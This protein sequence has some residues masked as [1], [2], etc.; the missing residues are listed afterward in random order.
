M[1][2][3]LS[4][5]DRRIG[6][7]RAERDGIQRNISTIGVQ[8]QLEVE[9]SRRYNELTR[10]LVQLDNRRQKLIATFGRANSLP[11]TPVS[12]P[13]PVFTPTT[14]TTGSVE[15]IRRIADRER[16]QVV[17][18]T[19][20]NVALRTRIDVLD[21]QLTDMTRR[22]T[23]NTGMGG[24]EAAALTQQ[25][26]QMR[27]LRDAAARELEAARETERRMRM[28]VND[29][30]N[31]A[32]MIER[33]LRQELTVANNQLSDALQ[34]T[35]TAQATYQS[36][37]GA[38][39][40]RIETFNGSGADFAAQRQRLADDARQIETNHATQLAAARNNQAEAERRAAEAMRVAGEERRRLAADAD[41]QRRAFEQA[42]AARRA[43]NAAALAENINRTPAN[44]A[45]LGAAAQDSRLAERNAAEA[46]RQTAAD[47]QSL[48]DATRV[49][50]RAAAEASAAA[51]LT[52]AAALDQ[53]ET[54]RLA[55]D[56]QQ[57]SGFVGGLFG[58][59]AGA[60]GFGGGNRQQ[61]PP[62]PTLGSAT[63]SEGADNELRRA[64]EALIGPA[65]SG[66]Q[67]EVRLVD[68]IGRYSTAVY[69]WFDENRNG[70]FASGSSNVQAETLARV[71]FYGTRNSTLQEA[72]QPRYTQD[73]DGLS[74]D[75]TTHTIKFYATGQ[76]MTAVV[77]AL[78]NP[79]LAYLYEAPYSERRN[80]KKVLTK[81]VVPFLW[82]VIDAIDRERVAA[83]T[84]EPQLEAAW[85]FMH[86]VVQWLFVKLITKSELSGTDR[87]MF[88]QQNSANL[89]AT[90]SENRIFGSL[91]SGIATFTSSNETQGSIGNTI[92]GRAPIRAADGV[93]V[94]P[95]IGALQTERVYTAT[96]RADQLY[97]IGAMQMSDERF[98]AVFAQNT[99][100][101]INAARKQNA[102][103][104]SKMFRGV[105]FALDNVSK[106]YSFAALFGQSAVM[107]APSG[108]D[109]DS[110]L[111]VSLFQRLFPSAALVEQHP[112]ASDSRHSIFHK[113]FT[114]LVSPN[115]VTFIGVEALPAATEP[116]SAFA[117]VI[118]PRADIVDKNLELDL[119]IV[120][121]IGVP[122]VSDSRLALAY[123]A[124]EFTLLARN[125]ES[126][127]RG[128]KLYA[129]VAAYSLLVPYRLNA[130]DPTPNKR[131]IERFGLRPQF[132]LPTSAND[133]LKGQ[134][135]VK[136]AAKPGRTTQSRV[137]P[138]DID[139][140]ERMHVAAELRLPGETME[141]T[142]IR[143]ARD[144]RVVVPPGY[145]LRERTGLRD[146][147]FDDAAQARLLQLNRMS[148]ETLEDT[149]R[150]L[151][152]ENRWMPELDQA[153]RMELINGERMPDETV[154]AA[155]L[156][157][158]REGR[159]G[160]G[161]A[162][163]D[164]EMR[165]LVANYRYPNESVEETRRRLVREGRLPIES[166]DET[167]RRLLAEGRLYPGEMGR[168]PDYTPA[169]VSFSRGREKKPN[170]TDEQ[171]RLRLIGEGKLDGETPEMTQLRLI[172]EGPKFGESY[173]AWRSR[174]MALG[175]IPGE[176]VAE[177][178][179]RPLGAPR[180]IGA[181]TENRG[182]KLAEMQRALGESDEEYRY[183]LINGGSGLDTMRL[184]G[185]TEMAFQ[186]RILSR[187]RPGLY[188][189]ED[190]RRRRLI[191]ELRAT[192]E[193]P[194]QTE[195][196][197]IREGK[198]TR[199][200][201]W[202]VR[203]RL[204]REGVILGE[205]PE[206]TRRRI[207]RESFYSPESLYDG[208]RALVTR[209]VLPDE[210]P[211]ETRQRL[212]SQG[213]LPIETNDEAFLRR[214]STI[215][216]PGE[217]LEEALH[218]L[219]QK[220]LLE[221]EG[222]FPGEAPDDA[223]RRI[224]RDQLLPGE[225]QEEFRARLAR[226]QR[227][228]FEGLAPGETLEDARRRFAS[229][230]LLVN[231]DTPDLTF[232]SSLLDRLRKMSTVVRNDKRYASFTR[233]VDAA[234]KKIGPIGGNESPN[235][236]TFEL[237]DASTK[238]EV[239][240]F[241]PNNLV[242]SY[243]MQAVRD[244]G[245]WDQYGGMARVASFFV[246]R[247]RVDIGSKSLTANTWH[248]FTS[249]N[250]VDEVHIHKD[251]NDVIR[252][253]SS[254]P[255]KLVPYGKTTFTRS[256][257][258]ESD[259]TRNGHYYVLESF[260][261]VTTQAPLPPKVFE[262]NGVPSLPPPPNNRRPITEEEFEE[263]DDDDDEDTAQSVAKKMK[264]TMKKN[265][266]GMKTMSKEK[267]GK[268]VGTVASTHHNT[269]MT[270]EEDVMMLERVLARAGLDRVLFARPSRTFT[271][272]SPT[273]DVFERFMGEF[274]RMSA[275]DRVNVLKFHVLR[276]DFD[277]ARVTEMLS[278]N[279]SV[280]TLD[281]GQ[282]LMFASGEPGPLVGRIYARDLVS[283]DRMVYNKRGKRHSVRVHFI[284]RI[285]TPREMPYGIIMSQ[286]EFHGVHAVP[287]HGPP[288]TVKG[289]YKYSSTKYSQRDNSDLAHI[290]ELLQAADLTKTLFK[291]NCRYTILVPS[292]S[293]FGDAE[294][295]F[296]Q[297]EFGEQQALLQYHVLMGDQKGD[298]IADKF[299]SGATVETLEGDTLKFIE[300]SPDYNDDTNGDIYS[301]EI[302]RKDLE[303]VDTDGTGNR[304]R[305]HVIS[306][307]LMPMTTMDYDSDEDKGSDDDDDDDDDEDDDDEDDDN[308]EEGDSK[309]R[310]AANG[311]FSKFH[312]LTNGRF[313]SWHR[314]AST[315]KFTSKERR[316]GTTGKFTKQ[317]RNASGQYSKEHR[318]PNGKFAKDKRTV[319]KSNANKK[320]AE[321]SVALSTASKASFGVKPVTKLVDA[322]EQQE[323]L[324]RTLRGTR[325]G[326]EA[327]T[328]VQSFASAVAGARGAAD[329]DAWG[330]M[331]HQAREALAVNI[332][333]QTAEK[334][335][336]HAEI[337]RLQH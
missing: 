217:T 195:E 199:E 45:S 108:N 90:A 207:A 29:V 325:S 307:V 294:E 128:T 110:T 268:M 61:P 251:S 19:A 160:Y 139:A 132:V 252:I 302:V 244:N 12:V 50:E 7:V 18:L 283:T 210:T 157:L 183:R 126:S 31:Q 321:P 63:S 102:L 303:L 336:A 70:T 275:T 97:L 179:Q 331:V 270:N 192:G 150:R 171:W 41:N 260:G 26:E 295:M 88:R 300:G 131:Y 214:G 33:Q 13:V 242:W 117:T 292:W 124:A 103:E 147:T 309:Q 72:R 241:I 135:T 142:L 24:A 209:Q 107:Y 136:S 149:R 315:G 276:G 105:R 186:Q 112:L 159:I 194:T 164:D 68:D 313:S 219:R 34:A 318:G 281:D 208:R 255:L 310:R 78:L 234:N 227:V 165:R 51:T 182:L 229:M 146:M 4:E 233:W 21:R 101:V 81:T 156:R 206:E 225:T 205:T 253:E 3:E 116:L 228:P 273:A 235:K 274:E 290:Y 23:T 191:G 57:Q 155:R 15:E 293:A 92:R 173:Y 245:G 288:G 80:D 9:K 154:E 180:P 187:A 48:A 285:L 55:R 236:S 223:R 266:T 322:K 44:I 247:G 168:E 8:S 198:L 272:F 329:A 86:Q 258:Y 334:K 324:L 230:G 35:R 6:V 54:Q 323:K 249:I 277:A 298:E 59:M 190:E 100:V 316:S 248:R 71:M 89:T 319:S 271:V 170:E 237:I 134:F 64:R 296:N 243:I 121:R 314:S 220:D 239:T 106:P 216:L 259:M 221:S 46:N 145:A 36:E 317:H 5:I 11:T 2:N 326:D 141:E 250:G 184:P 43:A 153:R 196:R 118:G 69:P 85:D 301:D 111:L 264:N 284:R 27:F 291:E 238:E 65:T 202:Q 203:D 16:A 254:A 74:Y 125:V 289:R 17:Q 333:L 143:L 335:A 218:R 115:G 178:N 263:D 84:P 152:E 200:M 38:L 224:A 120:R 14:S 53:A 328:A 76:S 162:M 25:L 332:N 82:L 137:L 30:R 133:A 114:R 73:K 161:S 66:K 42:E 77:E 119:S 94:P 56:L 52:N 98:E 163:R 246:V 297:M 320:D 93:L 95:M 279:A 181:P 96:T 83:S 148:G 122:P 282:R 232:S 287:T 104:V 222:L 327:T 140:E 37:L 265:K 113:L 306:R 261:G 138:T 91:D 167:L 188:E 123:F 67:L 39:R 256:T 213:A 176:T 174:M 79:Y 197:L 212:I 226:E 75:N 240:A 60:L 130:G 172:G 311:H 49:A 211:E 109:I 231:A 308:A 189:T 169:Y 177:M 166:D 312:R 32:Q 151:I 1:N 193:S 215:Q 22:A 62:T 201:A 99:G 286:R 127:V 262:G 129:T 204:M 158:L 337:T 305:V 47:Q 20:D 269:G 299:R 278:T 267:P 144:G 28:E 58:A 185:E 280:P 87:D 175:Y 40:Q 304:V 330:D 257:Q 10:E